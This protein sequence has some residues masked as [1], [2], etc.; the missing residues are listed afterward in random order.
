LARETSPDY[1][2]A[3]RSIQ[4]SEIDLATAKSVKLPSLNLNGS[5]GYNNTDNSYNNAIDNLPDHH[6]NNWSLGLTYT[7]PWGL[8]ADNARYAQFAQDAPQSA[9]PKPDRASA[10]RCQQREYESRERGHRRESHRAQRKTIR[11]TESAFRQRPLDQP[12]RAP[13]ARRSRVRALQ[14][15]L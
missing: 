9:R 2:A 5:L 13:G 12:S 3:A 15:T 14:R 7:M 8:K 6:G 4:Q 1:L 11:G 10:H